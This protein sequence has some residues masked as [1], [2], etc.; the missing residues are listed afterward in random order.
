MKIHPVLL[1]VLMV[2]CFMIGSSCVIVALADREPWCVAEDRGSVEGEFRADYSLI[3][4]R[5][6]T[7]DADG[8][9]G[10]ASWMF[11]GDLNVTTCEIDS[12]MPGEVWG[13][14]D[15]DTFGHEA[16]HCFIGEFHDE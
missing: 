7:N 12:P 4:W 6:E 10:E 8:Q 13:D 3:H 9:Y 5:R 16:L 1:M 14:I 15:M 11:D 2:V